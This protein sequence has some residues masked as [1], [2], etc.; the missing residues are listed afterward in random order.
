MRFTLE[1]EP[2][3]PDGDG[4]ATYNAPPTKTMKCE[5]TSRICAKVFGNHF[6]LQIC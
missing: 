6:S 1:K 3:V 4:D 2:T 5:M